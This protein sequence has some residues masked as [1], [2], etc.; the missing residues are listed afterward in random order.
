VHLCA[1]VSCGAGVVSPGEALGQLPQ[2]V[3]GVEVGTLAIPGQ[4]LAVQLYPVDGVDAR[5]VQVS[6]TQGRATLY[7]QCKVRLIQSNV[8]STYSSVR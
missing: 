3:E 6:G 1:G 2:P 7:L 8:K 5:Q 4:R